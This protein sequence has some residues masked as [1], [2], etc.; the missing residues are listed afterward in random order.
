[1]K[2]GSSGSHHFGPAW[3]LI[4]HR[5]GTVEFDHGLIISFDVIDLLIILWVSFRVQNGFQR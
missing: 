2:T 4:M 5:L 1:M 3:I